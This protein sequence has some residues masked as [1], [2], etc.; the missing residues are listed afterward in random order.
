M[1]AISGRLSIGEE[2]YLRALTGRLVGK[3]L[4]RGYNKVAIIPYPDRICESIAAAAAVAYLETFGYGPGKVAVFDY[5][6]DVSTLAEKVVSWKPEAIYI[7]FG[8]EQRMADV[9]NMTIK[10]LKALMDKGFKGSLLIHVRAWLATKQL[11]TVL[12]DPSLNKYLRS[13][14]EVKVFTAD[15]NAKKFFF[16][17]VKFKEGGVELVKYKEEDITDEH[18]QLLKLSLPPG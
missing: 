6:E 7:A 4:F 17:I 3:E 15:A 5:Q 12:A 2:V 13:L 1:A 10:L 16:N 11:S 8:G 9:N 14:K 18:A